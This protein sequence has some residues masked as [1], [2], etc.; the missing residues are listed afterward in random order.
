MSSNPQQQT[1]VRTAPV[2]TC[3]E[4]PRATESGPVAVENGSEMDVSSV[5]NDEE[6]SKLDENAKDEKMETGAQSEPIETSGKEPVPVYNEPIETSGK[7]PVPVYNEPIETSGKEPVP[8]YNEPI[9]TSGKEPVPVYN[10]PIETSGKEPVPVYNEPIETSGKEPVPVYNEPMETQHANEPMNTVDTGEEDQ[11]GYTTKTDSDPVAEKVDTKNSHEDNDSGGEFQTGG[12]SNKTPKKGAKNSGDV[13]SSPK[14]VSKESG[15]EGASISPS[16]KGLRMTKERTQKEWKQFVSSLSKELQKLMGGYWATEDTERYLDGYPKATDHPDYN[17][18]L[19]FYQNRL[20]SQPSGDYIDDIHKKWWSDYD[21]LEQH[22]GYIQWLFPIQ[23]QG[24]NHHAQPLQKHEIQQLLSEPE[25]QKFQNRLIRSYEL[26]L[27]FFGMKLANKD[28]GKIGRS[29][30]HQ[31]QQY[32][33]LNSSFHNYLRITRILKCLGEFELGHFQ[34]PFCSF[35][36][37][38]IF[39]QE[40]LTNTL[41]SCL[42]Y[43]GKVIVNFQERKEFYTLANH[44]IIADI[45]KKG[46]I[47]R[48]ELYR[49]Y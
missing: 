40:K 34:A 28:T 15:T 18:N 20:P 26:M 42:S 13:K 23:E 32:R 17:L 35:V 48:K 36:L 8:V 39:E 30:K 21:L 22:H 45:E 38:E 7:E 31:K 4:K 41:K 43:W 6:S 1:D 14:G 12:K 46:G 44:F 27:D 11:T 16:D 37:S 24:L 29:D 25:K 49:Y 33:L 9:E 3:D 10:E 19:E 2:N 47:V 5:R